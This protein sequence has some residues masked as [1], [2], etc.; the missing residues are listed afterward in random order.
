MPAAQR[1]H[2]RPDPRIGPATLQTL[3]RRKTSAQTH[4]ARDLRRDLTRMT[5]F[6]RR[7][8]F[9]RM[10]ALAQDTP[11][12]VAPAGGI[13]SRTARDPLYRVRQSRGDFFIGHSRPTSR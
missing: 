12:P 1:H 2:P 11:G 7:R 3:T 8:T 9:A 13:P 6:A 4:S 10:T 5:A